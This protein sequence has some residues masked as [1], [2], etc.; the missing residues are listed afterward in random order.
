MSGEWIWGRHSVEAACQL[1][2]E[3]VMET[4]VEGESADIAAVEKATSEAGLKLSRSRVPKSF[5]DKRTQGIVCRLK[6]FP[7]ETFES[8]EDEFSESLGDPSKVCQWAI[9][10]GVQDPRNYGAILRSAAAFGIQGVIV[11]RRDQSPLTGVVAQASA[12]QIF[13][14][15]NIVANNLGRVVQAARDSAAHVFALDGA[16]QPLPEALKQNV[17]SRVWVI[18]AEGEGVRKSLLDSATAKV[19]IPM[20]EGVESLNASVAAAIAFYVGA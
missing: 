4:I 2:P 11:G 16:G 1:V 19:C 18:G 17:G 6:Y 7:S 9:L 3:L 8:I 15:R 5:A 14:V 10:D 20:V 12:G 13:R